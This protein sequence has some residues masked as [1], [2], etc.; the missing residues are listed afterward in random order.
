MILIS[1]RVLNNI[2][3]EVDMNP[4][5]K[6]KLMAKIIDYNLYEEDNE[7]SL[8]DALASKNFNVNSDPAGSRCKGNDYKCKMCWK[9]TIKHAKENKNIK[10]SDMLEED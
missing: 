4:E 7:K 9:N 2:L 1:K 8:L 10:L 6:N 3:Y 5:E